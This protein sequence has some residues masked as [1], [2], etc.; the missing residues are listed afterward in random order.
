MH[1]QLSSGDVIADRRADYARMLE[2][3][4]EPDAAA[5]LMEQALELVPAWAAGWYR[6][7]T[8]REKAGRA[9]AAI[10]AYRNTL[11]LDPEDIFGSALKLAL[12]GDVA[13]PDRPPSRYVERL[14]DDYADRFESALVEKLDYLSLIHI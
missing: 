5:E 10:Q 6:L 1:H 13:T 3:G 2:E 4:G 14:F 7:A 9:E 12:L 8:Y 11:A